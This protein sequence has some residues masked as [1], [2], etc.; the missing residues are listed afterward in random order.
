MMRSLA[1]RLAALPLQQGACSA[2]SSVLAGSSPL[3]ALAASL[4]RL[5]LQAPSLAAAAQL[6]ARQFAAGAAGGS[7]GSEQP[8]A[9]AV[10]QQQGEQPT[11]IVSASGHLRFS[12]YDE[13]LEAWG[14]AMDEGDWGAAF[15]IFE[16]AYPVDTEEFPDLQELLEWDPMAEQKQARREREAE[17]RA[18]HAA[19]RVR[20]LD[21]VSGRAHAAGKRKTS[22]ALVWLRPAA[23]PGAG[24]LMVNRRPY[25]EYFP[26]LL[27]RNDLAAPFMAT[28]TLGNW[29]VMARV[30]GGGQ[31]GQ[32]QAV[33]HGIA[34]ALQN[35]DPVLRPPLKAAGLL[36]RDMRIVER[37]KPGL[38]KARK[39]FQ[40]VKR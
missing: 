3:A 4:Q 20:R 6:V 9:H 31:T 5:Q 35:W 38:K 18:M 32:S 22:V 8:P 17:I 24:R 34:R 19:R 30:S 14:K 7:G 11:E 21:P 12:N 16:G 29:D 1:A 15:D 13:V 26:D 28:G 36:A 10:E 2:A 25:D 23:A 40:W 33:R 39:A 37:K 27:R